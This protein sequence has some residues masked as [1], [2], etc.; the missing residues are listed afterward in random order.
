MDK[1]F[2]CSAKCWFN[3]CAGAG[4]CSCA[5]GF[6]VVIVPLQTLKNN[7]LE[8]LILKIFQLMKDNTNV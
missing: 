1:G 3:S 5:C 4:T 8:M 7:N 6:L 2:D